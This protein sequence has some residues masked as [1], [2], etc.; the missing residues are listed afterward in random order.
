MFI[1]L[2]KGLDLPISG[3]PEQCV[4]AATAVRHIAVVGVDYIDLK[5]AMNVAEGDR[6]KLG[7]PLFE[8][9][10]LPGVVFTAPGNRGN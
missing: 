4:Y 6:V 8:H 3:E 1:K 9:R 10:R 5:P 2:N 7:Q